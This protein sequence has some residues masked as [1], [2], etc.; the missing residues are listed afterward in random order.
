MIRLENSKYPCKT[1]KHKPTQH[2]PACKNKEYDLMCDSCTHYYCCQNAL[3]N[4]TACPYYM[5]DKEQQALQRENERLKGII[6]MTEQHF[7]PPLPFADEFDNEIKKAK[8]QAVL[9]F[10]HKL[11]SVAVQEGEYE[12]YVCCIVERLLREY[13]NEQSK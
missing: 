7:N 2:N 8:K 6:A 11:E 9:E 12:D 4:E 10:A 5:Q 3:D 1:C 13:K